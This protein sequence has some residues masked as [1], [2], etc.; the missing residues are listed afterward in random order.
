MATP[1]ACAQAE[2]PGHLRLHSSHTP[3]RIPQGVLPAPPS[4]S[5]LTR[6]TPEHYSLVYTQ[7]VSGPGDAGPSDEPVSTRLAPL[8]AAVRRLCE[9][10][11]DNNVLWSKAVRFP[12]SLRPSAHTPPACDFPCSAASGAHKAP[13]P[14]AA[15]H[16]LYPLLGGAGPGPSPPVLPGERCLWPAPSAP[17]G[18]SRN[19]GRPPVTGS[20]LGSSG[21]DLS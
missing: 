3:Y 18:V 15:R 17:A 5:I 7:G 19:P 8:K 4:E 10:Q 13:P 20:P 11:S 2:T 12:T 1:S 21:Q 14:R 16:I 6:T 9:C